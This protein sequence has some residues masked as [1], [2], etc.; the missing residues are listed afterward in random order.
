MKKE[1]NEQRICNACGKVIKST[2]GIY[3][4]AL[5]SVDFSWGYFSD[6]DGR[7]DHW[8]LCEACYDQITSSF[9]IPVETHE[10]TVLMD[11]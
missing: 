11:E 3:K 6:K 4:E 7:H 8:C 10:K 9:K 5:F 2:G 1:N